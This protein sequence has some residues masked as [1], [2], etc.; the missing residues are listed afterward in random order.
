MC[1]PASYMLSNLALQSLMC[2]IVHMPSGVHYKINI[3]GIFKKQD[4]FFVMYKNIWYWHS[5]KIRIVY[6]DLYNKYA[7]SAVQFNESSILGYCCS[8]TP[9]LRTVGCCSHV[10]TLIWYLGFRRYQS[11]WQSNVRD[12]LKS[13]KAHWEKS[14]TLSLLYNHTRDSQCDNKFKVNVSV[15]RFWWYH[16][17]IIIYIFTISI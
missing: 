15:Y 13:F 9:G 3:K 17:Y 14:K 12:M 11:T 1:G 16:Y 8:C 10:A 6:S 7:S 4:P 5:I 2:D